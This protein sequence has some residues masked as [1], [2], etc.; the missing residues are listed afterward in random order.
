MIFIKHYAIGMI[1]RS[2]GKAIIALRARR[3]DLAN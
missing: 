2:E 1:N 3:F